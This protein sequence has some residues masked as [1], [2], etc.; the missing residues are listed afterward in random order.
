[1]AGFSQNMI[2]LQM[3]PYLLYIPLLFEDNVVRRGHTT[4]FLPTA[5]IKDI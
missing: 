4:Y 5:E 3:F 1:M 2:A